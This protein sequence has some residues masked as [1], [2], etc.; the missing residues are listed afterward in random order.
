[1][2]NATRAA[3]FLV[4]GATLTACQNKDEAKQ[5]PAAAPQ[6]SFVKPVA[7][8]ID[9]MM[10][11]V[12]PAADF[13]W[14]SVA[15]ISTNKG[16]EERQPRTDEEWLAVRLKALQLAEAANLLMIPGRRVAH[17]GQ[18][19]EDEGTDGNLTQ[20]QAQAELDAHHD[21]FIAYA[22]ALRDT[23]V[24]AVEAIDKRDLDAYLEVGGRIDEACEQCHMKFWYPGAVVPPTAMR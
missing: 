9:L 15:T 7:S 11:Q 16:I 1:V 3:L 20:E 6:Q 24:Q 23:A 12:D 13:L 18:R 5:E 19:L 10:S 21:T 8:V 22:A 4:V 14:E 17:E 2:K